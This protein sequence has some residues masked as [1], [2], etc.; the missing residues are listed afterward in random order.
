MRIS[1]TAMYGC[2]RTVAPE[3]WYTASLPRPY[4]L[5]YVIGGHAYYTV[6]GER[7]P[8][9]RKY[10]Y[11]FPAS[12]HFNVV[13]DK[14][15][16][17]NHIYYDFMMNETVTSSEPLYCSVEDHPLLPTMLTLMENSILSYRYDGHTKLRDTVIS[18]LETF[19][20]LFLE[21]V[22]PKKTLSKDIS[23]AIEYIEQNYMDEISVKEIARLVFLDE[24][25]FIKKFKRELGVTPYSYIKNLRMAV[26]RELRCGGQALKDAAQSAGFKY[27]SSYCRA[28]SREKDK[29]RSRK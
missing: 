10:F 20:S 17:L 21:I 25:Y 8:L 28:L 1:I 3:D 23:Q 11:L 13:Q 16:R 9:K 6:G 15:D 22:E 27:P 19:L 14:S 24:G 18:T 7:I 26:A 4:R 29:E 12:M 2:G 5:Y